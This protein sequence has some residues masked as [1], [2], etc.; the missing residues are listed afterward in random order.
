[1]PQA[2]AQTLEAND[3]LVLS[4]PWGHHALLMENAEVPVGQRCRTAKN[5]ESGLYFSVILLQFVAV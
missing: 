3:S 2:V 1:V 4:I 5:R